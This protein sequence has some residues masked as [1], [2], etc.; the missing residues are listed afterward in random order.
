[1]EL[2]FQLMFEKVINFVIVLGALNWGLIGAFRFNL[3]TFMVGRFTSMRLNRIVYVLIGACA[4]LRMFNRDYYL[5][6]LGKHVFPCDSMELKIPKDADTITNVKVKKNSNVI[7]WASEGTSV[8]DVVVLNPSR[9]YDT[10]SNSGVAL[11]DKE[12]VAQLKFRYPSSYQVRFGTV[13]KPHVHYRV[14]LG[15]GMLG[16]V[17]TI[18]LK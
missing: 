1:M 15:N 7:Y 16:P 11:A 14:C 13:L 9:A 10:Y 18:F 8:D 4:L 12:G 3:V 2:Y 17:K 5:P 6:F